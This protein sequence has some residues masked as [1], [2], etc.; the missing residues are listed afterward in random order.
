MNRIRS[1]SIAVSLFIHTSVIGIM[2]GGNWM[3]RFVPVVPQLKSTEVALQFV[4][5]PDI[6]PEAELEKESKV[7]SDKT[8]SAKDTD[9]TVLEDK[10]EAKAK[11]VSYGKQLAKF[12][13]GMPSPRLAESKPMEQQ[14]RKELIEAEELNESL[15][16]IEEELQDVPVIEEAIQ[17]T[18]G[19][20]I[21]S[22]PEIS[23]DRLSSPIK[24]PLTFETQ[25]H[26]IGPYFKEIKR[27]IESYWLGYLILK[28]PNTAPL[29]SETTV[30]F[31]ILP[32]GEVTN[33]FVLDYTGD[34]IFRDF[35]L[36]TIS[37]TS[38]Y[39]PLPE[40]IDE[41]EEKGGLEIVFTF[42]YK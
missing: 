13:K 31:K 9:E 41:V 33:L 24:G 5:S 11:E 18:L 29:E 26:R 20:D 40:G 4:N 12:S 39:P 10:S 32:R 22:L 37:N 35:C 30:S 2:D 14:E 38:P 15:E 6:V 27:K 1:I 28:Y 17:D 19:D 8:L 34:I 7:I 42:R 36:A 3:Q 25:Y 21:V 23:E 16:S